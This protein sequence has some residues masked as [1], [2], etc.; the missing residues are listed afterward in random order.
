MGVTRRQF[1]TRVGQAG[2]YSAAFVA[3]Q[4]L[5]LMEARGARV[6]TLQAAPGSGRGTHVVVL[7]GGIAG[8]VTAYELNALGYKVTVLEARSRP[9]GRN[10]TVRGG[11]AVTLM[12]GSVQQCTWESGHYQN[13]GPARLPSIHPNI[14]GYC[15]KLGVE[16][17]VEVNMSR[18]AHL[19]NDA[20]MGGKPAV[21][22]QVQNDTRGHVSELLMKCMNQGALD[23]EI[24]GDDRQRMLD[25][26]RVYGPLDEAGKYT[27][28][29][30]AGYSRTAGA[31]DVTGILSQPIDMHTLLEAKFWQGMLFDEQF[32]MQATMF[33]PVGGMDRVPYAF[34]KALGDTV[35]YGAAVTGMQNT[36]HGVSVRYTQGGATK[37]LTADY[38]IC[39][40]PLTT[41]RKVENNL[42]A[43]YKKVV[44]E[45][46]YAQAYKIAWESRRF[47]EQDD[48]IYGGLEF[49]TTGCSPIWF[50]SAG[51]F[52]ERGVVVSGYS[53]E[54]NTPFAQLSTEAKF[55][56]S[57]KSIERLHPG[58]GQ[59]LQK[60]M[61]YG[62]GKSQWNEGSWIRSY[63]AQQWEDDEAREHRGAP[64]SVPGTGAQAAQQQAPGVA[65][66]QQTGQGAAPASAR[67][68]SNP[69]Y[70]QLL[71]PDARILFAGDHTTHVVAWQEGA[72]LSALRAVQWVSDQV[73][74]AR[75]TGVDASTNA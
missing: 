20:A 30:R 32:D 5:G 59:E 73:K 7:G 64:N 53:D 43:P 47:W 55:A 72:A 12:D 62:W 21:M 10:Y 46:T 70:E 63:G 35:Q 42:P 11:D 14:L 50:P 22:R 65:M 13:F 56:E 69:G 4:G 16:L 18:S 24:T 45:S 9:G 60:P 36:A 38:G 19:Q 25:F 66:N 41:L 8:L 23:A 71:Q 37:T 54:L 15:R 39:A 33:Q 44:A 3:M 61:Y 48:N 74:A 68:G 49:C 17:Q 2:G 27:G 57:R 40:L 1:L 67:T 52:S 75:L 34:A 26:L 58:H 31:G 51:L 29:D 28:S 6:A